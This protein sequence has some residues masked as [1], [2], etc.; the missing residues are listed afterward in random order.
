MPEILRGKAAQHAINRNMGASIL[1]EPEERSPD[2]GSE[3]RS[4]PTVQQTKC[5][6]SDDELEEEDLILNPACMA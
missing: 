4:D 5:Q 2:S 3:Y 1:E 6:A